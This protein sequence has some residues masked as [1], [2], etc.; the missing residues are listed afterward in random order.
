MM[1]VVHYFDDN[2]KQHMSFVQTFKEVM[3]LKERFG[4]VTVE[5]YKMINQFFRGINSNYNTATLK[6][7]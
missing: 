1:Y 5:S 4:E 6:I 7:I 2:H 3:F